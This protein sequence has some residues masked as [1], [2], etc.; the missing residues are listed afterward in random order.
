MLSQQGEELEKV[1]DLEELSQK[2]QCII[3]L[4]SHLSKS[5]TYSACW[6]ETFAQMLNKNK[7]CARA[8]GNS[9]RTQGIPP[10]HREFPPAF[11]EFHPHSGNSTR[12]QGIPPALRDFH[13]HSRISTR[14]QEFHPHSR[15]STRTLRIPPAHREFPPALKEFHPHLGIST[16]TEEIQIH[17]LTHCVCLDC[18]SSLRM[19][20]KDVFLMFFHAFESSNIP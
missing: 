8:G 14:T 7:W 19:Y 18:H 5:D 17:P 13:P 12:T 9:T 16:R 1:C 4:F 20:L 15:N 3:T 11:K 6:Y 10:A 2:S